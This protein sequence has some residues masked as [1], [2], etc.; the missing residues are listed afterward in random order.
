[1][2]DKQ[3]AIYRLEEI[4]DEI[5]ALIGEAMKLVRTHGSEL[6]VQRFRGYPYAHIV[7]ALSNSH[8]FLGGSVMTMSDVIEGMAAGGDDEDD[9][10]KD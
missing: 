4:R 10:D 6:D 2:S 7:G 8:E 5:A 1:M 3:E 9:S